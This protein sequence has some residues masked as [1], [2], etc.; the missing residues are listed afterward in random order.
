MDFRTKPS[1]SDRR[2]MMQ[3]YEENKAFLYHCACKFTDSEHDRE[4]ITQ[5]ALLK[6]MRNLPTLR[7]LS[8]NQIATYL[9]LTVCSV[10]ADRMKSAQGRMVYVSDDTW[11]LADENPQFA[12]DAKWDTEI[13]KKALSERDWNLLE[14]KYILGYTD[15]EIAREIGC[16]ADSV[17]TLLR[18]ARS[19]AKGILESGKEG[20]G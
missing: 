8:R 1:E 7:T 19:R 11:E 13:I 20:M 9:Y 15:E 14:Y 16:A 18:R 6:L 17:R 4:D 2:F 10:Y 5:D 3:F 12:Y